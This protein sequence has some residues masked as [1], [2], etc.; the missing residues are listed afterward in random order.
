MAIRSGNFPY[1]NI[2][3]SLRQIQK[4]ALTHVNEQLFRLFSWAEPE[5][6]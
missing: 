4:L 3:I 5:S 6:G 1:E 2:F